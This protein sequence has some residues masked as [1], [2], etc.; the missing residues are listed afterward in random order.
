MTE[1]LEG[2]GF[3]GQHVLFLEAA[4]L[5]V[6]ERLLRMTTDRSAKTVWRI[7]NRFHEPALCY[8]RR[9]FVFP[10]NPAYFR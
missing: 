7:I 6:T 5:G 10:C 3:D 9:I 8:G 1:I 2:Q 4:M